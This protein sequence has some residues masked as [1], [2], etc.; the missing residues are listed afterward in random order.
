[1]RRCRASHDVRARRPGVLPRSPSGSPACARGIDD[2]GKKCA[3]GRVV[4]DELF[5]VPLHG[6]DEAAT[7]G[8][9]ER[10]DD[11]VGRPADV[12]KLTA[13]AMNGLMMEA[14]HAQLRAPDD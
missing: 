6:D 2:G 10:L 1:M 11:V 14:V 5:G 4:A 9:L 3:R 13:E 12:T 8:V 7:V